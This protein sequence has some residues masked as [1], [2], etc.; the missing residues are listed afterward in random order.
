[1]EYGAKKLWKEMHALTEIIWTTERKGEKQ[2]T[3][4]CPTHKKEDKIP[5]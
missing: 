2:H 1:M 5:M 4:I 3:A